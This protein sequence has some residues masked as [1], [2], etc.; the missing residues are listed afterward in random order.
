MTDGGLNGQSLRAEL[1]RGL[2]TLQLPPCPE[3]ATRWLEMIPWMAPLLEFA[4]ARMEHDTTCWSFLDKPCDCGL[5]E[6]AKKLAEGL[7]GN[8]ALYES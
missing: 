5:D 4:R 6:A 7:G 1:D 3:R 2:E 8:E